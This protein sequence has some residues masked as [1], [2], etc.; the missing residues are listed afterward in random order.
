MHTTRFGTHQADTRGN[1]LV[2]QISNKH[3]NMY[4]IKQISGGA[5]LVNNLI[6]CEHPVQLS[7]SNIYKTLF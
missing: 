2:K 7:S 5:T 3:Y 1:E 6:V 4:N